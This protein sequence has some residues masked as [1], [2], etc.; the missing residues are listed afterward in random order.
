LLYRGKRRKRS[1]L[2]RAINATDEV[3]EKPQLHGDSLVMPRHELESERSPD[4]TA[5]LPVREPAAGELPEGAARA[6]PAEFN[7]MRT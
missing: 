7:R 2:A 4:F 6:T 5:E 1:S 3:K